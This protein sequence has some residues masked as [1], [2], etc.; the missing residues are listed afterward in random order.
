MQREYDDGEKGREK[1]Y[2]IRI[3]IVADITVNRKGGEGACR[4]SLLLQILGKP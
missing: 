1:G 4:R 3:F 2:F